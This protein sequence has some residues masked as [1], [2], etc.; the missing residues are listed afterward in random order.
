[1]KL[2]DS[3]ISTLDR[4]CSILNAFRGNEKTLTLTEISRRINLPKS[5]TFRMLEAL[6]CQGVITREPYSHG[7]QLGYQLIRWGTQALDNL[8]MRNM[9]QPYLNRLMNATGETAVLSTRVGNFGMWLQVVESQH[10][11]RLAVKVGEPLNL[12]AGASSKVLWAFLP[13]ADIEQIFTEITLIPIKPNTITDA[14]TLRSELK[15]IRQRG[16]ATSFEETDSGA[17]GIAAPVYNHTNNPVAG[18]GIAAPIARV[19]HDRIPELASIVLAVSFDLSKCLGAQVEGAVLYSHSSES[20]I[21]ERG[22]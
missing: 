2:I 11:V 17:M 9:A 3:G 1:M 7:Y 14:N 20:N 5:T 6:E 13:D 4:V 15:T 19:P 21:L 16:Y 18:I 12:H 22:V 10:P 8:D